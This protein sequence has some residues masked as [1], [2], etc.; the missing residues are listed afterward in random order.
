MF[1]IQK[2]GLSFESKT[3]DLVSGHQMG[4]IR[5]LFETVY[6]KRLLVDSRLRGVILVFYRNLRHSIR[7]FLRD[8]D[9]DTQN[10][11]L[12]IMQKNVFYD[13]TK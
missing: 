8:N 2:V 7:L 12:C 11:I 5:T 10:I 6:P 1:A 3:K 4:G 13:Y 9:Q